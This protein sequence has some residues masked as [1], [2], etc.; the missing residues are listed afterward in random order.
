MLT[1]FRPQYEDLWFRQKMLADE[2]TMSYN[3]AWGGTI[4][5]PEEKWESW[6]RHWLVDHEGRRYYRYLKNEDGCY[7]G[8]AAYHYDAGLR[9][10]LADILIFSPYRGRGYGSRALELLCA[11]AKENGVPVLYDEIAAD[12]P[13]VTLFLRHGFA[14]ESRTEETIILKRVL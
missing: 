9:R 8:E 12:N 10:F 11:A 5:W 6:Y 7:V 4:P 3:R 1:L 13:A 2:E 14:E